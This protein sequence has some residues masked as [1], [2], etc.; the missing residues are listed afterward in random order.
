M[1]E[2]V[3]LNAERV[4][5]LGGPPAGVSCEARIRVS[6]LT[7][8]LCAEGWSAIEGVM[9]SVELERVLLLSGSS[10]NCNSMAFATC[11]VPGQFVCAA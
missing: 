9:L 10:W 8:D 1:E 3:F 11:C 2:G 4:R 7:V 5:L 6:G